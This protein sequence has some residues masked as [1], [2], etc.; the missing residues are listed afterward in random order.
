MAGVS[1]IGTD[2][3]WTGHH[4]AQANW[5]AFG[6]LAWNHN[7]EP[8]Q[9]ADEWIKMTFT[10]NKAFVRDIQKIMLSSREVA[11]NY[12]T[13]LGLHHIMDK[14]HHYG[15]GPWISQGRED[16][17]SVYYHRADTTGIGF[18]RTRTGSNALGQYSQKINELYSD[19]AT[20]PDEYLLW[21]YHLPWDYRMKSGISLWEEICRAYYSGADS[22]RWMQ[23]IWEMQKDRIDHERFEQVGEF[24]EIQAKEA[25]WCS[26]YLLQICESSNRSVYCSCRRSFILRNTSG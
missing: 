15:P 24:L 1:N 12:M 7:L 8:G 2:R 6:R 5:Y 23:G 16:W 18:D 22:V 4:F 11:V 10:N 3:N 19:P 9:I 17:T 25:T 21:F 13:P 20:C 26:V 14:G